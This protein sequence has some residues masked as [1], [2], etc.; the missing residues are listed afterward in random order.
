M[1]IVDL[2]LR[3]SIL[4]AWCPLVVGLGGDSP[5]WALEGQRRANDVLS[6]IVVSVIKCFVCCGHCVSLAPV[7]GTPASF[8]ARPCLLPVFGM[9]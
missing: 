4:C 7:T 8:S 2:R 9:T 6:Y 5:L 3:L 1:Y